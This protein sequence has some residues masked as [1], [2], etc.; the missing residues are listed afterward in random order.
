VPHQFG[1]IARFFSGINNKS[2]EG[3][4]LVNVEAIRFNY[5]GRMRIILYAKKNIQAGD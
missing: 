4:K 1:N 3:K 2:K 5:Q